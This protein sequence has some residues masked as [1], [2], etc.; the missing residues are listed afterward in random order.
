[1]TTGAELLEGAAEL[2]A[3]QPEWFREWLVSTVTK[4]VVQLGAIQVQNALHARLSSAVELYR[5]RIRAYWNELDSSLNRY[6]LNVLSLADVL[7]SFD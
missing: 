6:L 3:S 7:A 2:W 4:N 1:M 5:E